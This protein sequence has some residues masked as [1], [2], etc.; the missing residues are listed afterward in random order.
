MEMTEDLLLNL[1][2]EVTGGA[3]QLE[4]NGRMIQF[5]EKWRRV[6]FVEGL[7]EATKHRFPT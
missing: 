3:T 5:G 4:V 6:S 7:E 2:K 1:V